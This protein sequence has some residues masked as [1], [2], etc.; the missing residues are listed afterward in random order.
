MSTLMS[1]QYQHLLTAQKE[2]QA[3]DVMHGQLAQ[4]AKQAINFMH[5][6]LAD[7]STCTD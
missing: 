1:L 7:T 6:H 2:K 4:K 3:Y 5:E